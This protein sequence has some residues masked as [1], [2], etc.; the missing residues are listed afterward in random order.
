[1]IL[2]FASGP[3]EPSAGNL[4]VAYSTETPSDRVRNFHHSPEVL[5][6][7]LV[8]PQSSS[9]PA[10]L[11][12]SRPPGAPDWSFRAGICSDIQDSC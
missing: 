2:A 10:Q 7:V 4:S 8:A 9:G 3:A 1:M 5:L 6:A 11:M 12:A